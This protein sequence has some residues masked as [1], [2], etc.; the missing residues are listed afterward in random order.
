MVL[1]KDTHYPHV[2]MEGRAPFVPFVA[3]LQQHTKQKKELHLTTI[4]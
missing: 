4:L 1:G 3:V 2:C